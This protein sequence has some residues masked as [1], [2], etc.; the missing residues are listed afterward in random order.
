MKIRIKGPS[1]R[2]RLSR[3]EVYQ[4]VH[5]GR[6]EETTPFAGKDFKYALEKTDSG[7]TLHADFEGD[8]ITMYVPQRLI[9]NWDT[10]SLV[11]ID[12]N[13]D[14]PSGTSL[15]LLLEKDFQCLDK[16]EEDQSDNYINPNKTC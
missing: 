2:L 10:N 14:L 1:L 8:V 12:A 11:T 5:E 7:D 9:Q 6:I 13:M 3:S 16:T 4:L 15:Y